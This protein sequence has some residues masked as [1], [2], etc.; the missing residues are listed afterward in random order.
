MHID[1]N[2]CFATIEQQANPKLRGKPVVVAAYVTDRG[3]I[4]A[5]SYEAKRAGVM[6][7][8]RVTEGKRLCPSLIVLP[9]DP[10][11]YRYVNSKLT[12][13]LGS[14]TPDF[15]VKSIDELVLQ[16]QNTPA[17]QT[18]RNLGYSTSLSMR[19]LGMELKYR[20]KQEIGEWLTVSVGIGPN[21]FL[22][23]T[24]SNLQKP[25]G[26][27]EITKDNI[28]TVLGKLSVTDLTGIKKGWGT[29]LARYGITN[30]LS[31]YKAPVNL[32]KSAFS[33]VLGLYWHMWLHGY[34]TE[35]TKKDRQKTIGHSLA[36][37]KPF[38]PSQ[39]ELMQILRQLTDKTGRR[40]RRDGYK[41][42]GTHIS[43]LYSDYSFWH[44]GALG[45]QALSNDSDIYGS[46]KHIL[47]YAPN[48][49]VRTLAVSLFQL[50]P[51]MYTQLSFD[52]VKNK[53]TQVTEAL[54]DIRNTW[55]ERSI[56]PA[57]TLTT[58]Q[59]ILDRISFGNVKPLLD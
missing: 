24:A 6:T 2:S 32:L 16:L 17:Y 39:N 36:L 44:K 51:T 59:K 52:T 1:L 47:S 28:E 15:T 14:Y 45:A 43:C 37:Y 34:E 29:R 33:S 10:P 53:Q 8:M 38:S 26:L 12:C 11:K 46:A 20:I 9:S 21:K 41:A 42:Y 48:K 49:P 50:Q 30:A 25:D 56:F 57:S 54:D 55:G 13:L 5:A 18:R 35:E 22:A 31:L 19:S 40:M 58:P 7:G 23:K 3:C 4:L 27:S